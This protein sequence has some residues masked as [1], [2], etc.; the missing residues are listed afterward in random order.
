MYDSYD[1][2]SDGHFDDEEFS[3]M[4]NDLG[5]PKADQVRPVCRLSLSMSAHNFLKAG[6][7][8]SMDKDGNHMVDFEEFH[9]VDR[10]ICFARLS[11]SIFSLVVAN[12]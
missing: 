10:I 9:Q 11:Y 8:L 12:V 3:H 6:I 2:N 5:V 7:F 4:L 1:S